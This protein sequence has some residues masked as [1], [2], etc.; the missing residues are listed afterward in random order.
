MNITD[1]KSVNSLWQNIY[2]FLVAQI[3]ELYSRDSG[4]VLELGPFAGGISA[5]LALA[6][7]GMDITIADER[8]EMLEAFGT[9][10]RAAGAAERIRVVRSSL[11]QLVFDDASFDL[12]IFRGAFF[13][14]PDRPQILSEA[15]RVLKPGGIGFIGGGY[16]KDATPEAIEAISE[17]SREL[18]ER[19]G[20]VWL[21]IDQLESL[22][23]KAGIAP[24]T[25]I[26]QEGGVWLVITA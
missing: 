23:K 19:L 16:G 24:R 21:S 10:A 9:A 18:N 6:R 17:E 7:P 11:G 12:V 4:H 13:F 15:C 22:P 26:C 1:L 5:E 2:P 25:R 14:L 20:R 8:P 3:L